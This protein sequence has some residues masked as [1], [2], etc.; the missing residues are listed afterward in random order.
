VEG[1]YLE[2]QSDLG[3]RPF[4]AERAKY[5]H[6]LVDSAIRAAGAF[7]N[8]CLPGCAACC[9]LEVQ[10]TEEE[11]L[12]LD[13]ILEGGLPIDR[14][15]LEAQ[16]ALLNAEGGWGAGNDVLSRRCVFLGE[17]RLC[18]IYASRPMSCRKLF[19]KTP[20][21]WCG[22]EGGT[23]EVV[24][25]LEVEIVLSAVLG[26]EGVRVGSLPRVLLERLSKKSG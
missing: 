7:E 19:V 17:D 15:R 13:E 21:E 18:R 16:V 3:S 24:G 23:V 11:A 22:E 5:I 9:H 8:S 6:G 12:L 1:R 4:G 2:I 26:M 14:P 20:A 25:L 10:V